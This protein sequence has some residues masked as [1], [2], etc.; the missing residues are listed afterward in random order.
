MLLTDT[1]WGAGLDESQVQSLALR[2]MERFVAGLLLA[3]VFFGVHLLL[4]GF[5]LYRS[6]QV[7]RGLSLLLVAGGIGYT[8]GCLAELFVA[9]VGGPAGVVLLAPAVVGQLGFTWWLLVNGNEIV[10]IDHRRGGR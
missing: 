9:D 3:L 7:P 5:L 8:V 6:R 1:R 10:D 2:A 4:L